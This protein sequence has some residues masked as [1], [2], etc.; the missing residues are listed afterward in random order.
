[1]VPAG[2]VTAA[3]SPQIAG[4]QLYFYGYKF[5]LGRSFVHGREIDWAAGWDYGGQ[6]LFIVPALDIV[7]LAH[8][9][10]YNSSDQS[11]GPLTVLSRYVLEAAD[12][13]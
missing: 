6:R 1:V 4:Q 9:G 8:A 7:V 5:W 2:W 10:L 12:A 13:R 11:V 3:T